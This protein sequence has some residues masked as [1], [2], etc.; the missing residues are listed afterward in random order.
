VYGRPAESANDK[1]M[2]AALDMQGDDTANKDPDSRVVVMH[3]TPYL[4]PV[5]STGQH[6]SPSMKSSILGREA[7]KRPRSLKMSRSP[8]GEIWSSIRTGA[9]VL[10]A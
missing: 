9:V 2:A 10:P 4:E 7:S 3:I 8:F 5:W 1:L 6:S